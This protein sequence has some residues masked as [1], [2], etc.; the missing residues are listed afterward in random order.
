MRVW[1]ELLLLT[2]F[3]KTRVRE[4]GQV[5]RAVAARKVCAAEHEPAHATYSR[6]EKGDGR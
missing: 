2:V 3:R 6:D 4:T 5:V 1:L